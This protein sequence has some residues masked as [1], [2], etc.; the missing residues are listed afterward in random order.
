MKLSETVDHRA[1]DVFFMTLQTEEVTLPK[2][3][4]ADFHVF[5]S[6]Q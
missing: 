5:H 4:H 1:E 2:A 3:L 6:G